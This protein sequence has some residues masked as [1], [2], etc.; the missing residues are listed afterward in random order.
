MRYVAPVIPALVIL[1]VFGLRN[2]LDRIDGGFTA[3]AQIVGKSVVVVLV[4]GL[5]CLNAVYIGQLYQ[6]I[7]PISYISGKLN[8]DQYIERY[9]PEYAAMRFAN[10]TLPQDARIFGLFLG[11]RS[12]YSDRELIFGDRFFYQTVVRES[13]AREIAGVLKERNITHVLVYYRILKRW[14][15]QNFNLQERV[16]LADFFNNHASLVFAK[17][18]YGLYKL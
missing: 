14:S 1:S 11:N 9:R 18:E 13:S 15:G 5:L 6:R 10:Q 4:G 12:Y 8:R 16:K 3:S 17:G 2:I 7:D